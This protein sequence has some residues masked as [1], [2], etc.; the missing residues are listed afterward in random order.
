MV[1]TGELINDGHSK[2]ILSLNG[3]VFFIKSPCKM[4]IATN[5]IFWLSLIFRG[6]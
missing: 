5:H 3:L 6:L 2:M 1:N 4:N